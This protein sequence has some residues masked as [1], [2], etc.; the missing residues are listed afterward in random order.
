MGTLA[1]QLLLHRIRDPRGRHCP[2]RRGRATRPQEE[3]HIGTVHSEAPS[4]RPMR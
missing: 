4:A 1:A 2:G 3:P